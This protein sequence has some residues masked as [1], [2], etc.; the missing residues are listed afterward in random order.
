VLAS[1]AVKLIFLFFFLFA[2]VQRLTLYEQTLMSCNKGNRLISK[3]SYG[4]RTINSCQQC[5]DDSFNA[6]SERSDGYGM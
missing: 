4:L 5:S 1:L 2:V 3:Q 6:I